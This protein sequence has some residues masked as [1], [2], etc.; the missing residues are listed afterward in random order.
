MTSNIFGSECNNEYFEL[1]T[2][3]YYFGQ[4]DKGHKGKHFVCIM[5]GKH[6]VDEWG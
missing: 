4:R 1:D 5:N 2:R 3:T 6:R